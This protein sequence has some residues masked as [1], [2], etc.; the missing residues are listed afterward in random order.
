MKLGEGRGK[1]WR[2]LGLN[3]KLREGDRRMYADLFIGD[4]IHITE[5]GLTVA[6]SGYFGVVRKRKK[7]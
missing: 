2:E 6:Q 4:R 7:K 5:E 3:I 1:Q